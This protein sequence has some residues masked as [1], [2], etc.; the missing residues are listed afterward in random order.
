MNLLFHL[1]LLTLDRFLVVLSAEAPEANPV[2]RAVAAVDS[3]KT[4]SLDR[5]GR[6]RR[7]RERATGA[8]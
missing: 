4:D 6:R 1:P 3:G 5:R 8:G 7:R 2:K